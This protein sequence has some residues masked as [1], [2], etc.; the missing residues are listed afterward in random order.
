MV[1]NHYLKTLDIKTTDGHAF[2]KNKETDPTNIMVNEAFVK[3]FDLPT[4]VGT[5]ID[6]ETIIGV[7]N[8][9]NFN[10]LHQS[11]GP[12]I[13]RLRDDSQ[14]SMMM[15]VNTVDLKEMASLIP[16]IKNTISEIVPN[17]FIDI[18]FLNEKI[19]QQYKKETKTRKLLSYFSFFAIFISI[20][21]LFGLVIFITNRRIKEIGIRKI[22]GAKISEVIVMLNKSIL[23]W[24]VI[25]F[26]IA[27]PFAWY[28]M[29]KWLE[30]YAY[31]TDLNWW[32]FAF[33][34]VL[35][36]GIALITVSWQSWKA[37]TKN[38]IDSLRYE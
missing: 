22:N 17:T 13:I 5:V 7:V 36:M 23:V 19:G 16:N 24:V 21:G 32:I 34:G 14:T 2:Y 20:M 10:S 26:I 3:A 6:N 35:T 15:R 1:S 30:N 9:F 4:P 37:A 33:A 29:H 12:M 31:K 28:A 38:P 27:L 11:V 25:A 18:K 8:D